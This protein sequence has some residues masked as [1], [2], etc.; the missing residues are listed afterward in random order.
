MKIEVL[1]LDG[2]F[3]ALEEQLQKLE[4]PINPL[5]RRPDIIY[6][7]HEQDLA[8]LPCPTTLH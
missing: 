2:L 3:A 7:G 1:D 6:L 8:A 4:A 5:T